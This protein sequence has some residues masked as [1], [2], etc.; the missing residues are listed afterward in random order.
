MDSTRQD[1]TDAPSLGPHVPSHAAPNTHS[2]L[3]E[4]VPHQSHQQLVPVVLPHQGRI[5]GGIHAREV[6]HGHVRLPVVVDGEVQRRQLLLG[7]EVG[8]LPGVAQQGLLVHILPGEQELRVSVVLSPETGG[9]SREGHGHTT[10]PAPRVA[11]CS[12]K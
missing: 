2:H 11:S 4:A 3:Q 10:F 8:C 9:G 6:E 1:D 7:G 12:N 5:L